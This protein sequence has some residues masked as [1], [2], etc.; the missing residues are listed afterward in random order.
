MSHTQTPNTARPQWFTVNVYSNGRWRS[1]GDV[2]A[3]DAWTATTKHPA[4]AR[5]ATDQ[6]Q[7]W[8]TDRDGAATQLYA[9]AHGGQPA[10]TINPTNWR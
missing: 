1:T 2:L 3:H 7:V 4:T 6:F 8:H 9:P 10:Y 5:I